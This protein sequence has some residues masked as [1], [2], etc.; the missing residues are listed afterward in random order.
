MEIIVASGKGG[1]GKSTIT[2]SLISLLKDFS[3]T[4]VDADAEAPNLHIL[5]D[6][7]HWEE[8]RE[9]ISAHTAFI[10]DS[11]INCGLCDDVCVYEAIYTENG[12]HRIKEYLCE[13]C[14]ACKA[15]CP[16]NAITIK[17]SRSGWIRTALTPYGLLVSAEL[18]VGKPNSGKLV[19]EEKKIAREWV[20]SKKA[21]HII[22]DSAAG[23]GCQ[24]IASMSG[25]DLALLIAEPTPSSLSDLKRAYW[26]A[27]HFRIKAYIVVNKY[28]LNPDFKGIE[29][30]A[31]DKGLEILGKIPYDKTV[32]KA[33]ASMKPV[34][35]FAPDSK[36]ALEIKNLADSVEQFL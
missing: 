24:V 30:F 19:T 9:I 25:A 33:I 15:V 26:L 35:E 5:F 1:V 34:V 4:A 11:C 32:P 14:G 31:A 29:N 18:D 8:E 2:A 3:I 21:E 13:G 6:V 7:K 20:N 27:E 36:A 10:M 28:N 22:V 16:A 12:A 23:I 17:P